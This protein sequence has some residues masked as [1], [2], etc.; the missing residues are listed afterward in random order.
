MDDSVASA[1][2]GGANR[3]GRHVGVEPGQAPTLGGADGEG[4]RG[5]ADSQDKG[6]SDHLPALAVHP[7]DER[8]RLPGS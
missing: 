3:E 7:D 1:P 5:F 4:C 6:P 8:N 2:A